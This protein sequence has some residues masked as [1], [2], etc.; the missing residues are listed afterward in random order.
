MI[1]PAALHTA[2]FVMRELKGEVNFGPRLR[3]A[4][5]QG[6]Y[7]AMVTAAVARQR[8]STNDSRPVTTD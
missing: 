5:T 1:V 2:Y 8:L 3:F 4:L 6:L 7:R